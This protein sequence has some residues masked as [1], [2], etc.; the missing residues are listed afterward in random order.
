MDYEEML[1]E[2][3]TESVSRDKYRHTAADAARQP[4]TFKDKGYVFLF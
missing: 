3:V 4:C 1:S 2:V